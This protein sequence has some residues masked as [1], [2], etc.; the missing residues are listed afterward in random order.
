LPLLTAGDEVAH[1]ARFLQPG[2]DSYSA[3][4]VLSCLLAEAVPVNG[5]AL[6]T[7]RRTPV[8]TPAATAR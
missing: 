3:A 4:D 1:I 7:A 2:A 8:S 6:S 5:F